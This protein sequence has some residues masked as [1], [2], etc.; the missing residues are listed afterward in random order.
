[1]LIYP[2]TL[3]ADSNGT[4]RISLVDFPEANSVVKRSKRRDARRPVPLPSPPVADQDTA[5]LPALEL[6]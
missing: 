1:M 4:L 3:T 6:Q 5:T 2:V